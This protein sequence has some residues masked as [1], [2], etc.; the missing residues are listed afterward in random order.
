MQI[1][2]W[3]IRGQLSCLDVSPKVRHLLQRHDVLALS[4]TGITGHHDAP[5]IAQF[6]CI[7]CKPRPYMSKDGGVA[8]Y[9][10]RRHTGVTLVDEDADMGSSW[11]KWGNV[12]V[13]LVYIPPESSTVYKHS[14][15]GMDMSD[16]FTKL[17]TFKHKDTRSSCVETSMPELA[18]QRTALLPWGGGQSGRGDGGWAPCPTLL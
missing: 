6:R 3:N 17:A 11:I 13:G 9:V 18:Q 2:A 15:I 5:D 14:D 16:P 10:K 7:S 8:I 4:H 1:L 12:I